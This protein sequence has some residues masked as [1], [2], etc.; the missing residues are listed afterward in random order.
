MAALKY[1]FKTNQKP[2]RTI[3][4]YADDMDTALMKARA[5]LEKRCR[6]RGVAYPSGW[7]V[8]YTS[9]EIHWKKP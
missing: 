3:T 1:H 8:A 4:V 6:K 5:E 2:E 7:D 9:K